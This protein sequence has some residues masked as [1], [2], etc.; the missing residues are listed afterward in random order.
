MTDNQHI[1]NSCIRL[2]YLKKRDATILFIT[3][4]LPL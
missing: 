1:N 2:F 4:L 3:F